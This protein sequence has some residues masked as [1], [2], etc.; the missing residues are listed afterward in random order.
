MS[1]A[2]AVFCVVPSGRLYCVASNLL[3]EATVRDAVRH[4]LSALGENPDRP[5][6]LRTPERV[7]ESLLDLTRGYREPL[8]SIL[9]G[10]V[11]EDPSQ[12]MVLVRDIPFY[13]LCEHHLLPFFGRAHV[14]YIPDGRLMGL[15]KIPRVIEHF[16][17][18]LQVQERLTE[19]VAEALAG[20]LRPR[21]LGV[22]L[23]A[24]HLCMVMRGV[25]KEGSV[26]ATSALRGNFLSDPRARAE[27]LA[28]AG[29][30]NPTK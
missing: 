3:V 17:R 30:P 18:R 21:G 7:E 29:V 2:P 4:I 25:Q 28:L 13:S 14:A 1:K 24:T 20:A 8:D 22:V 9:N 19:Q 26:A 12:A 6:L 10:A 27:F 5:E 23:E 15:S 16:A 11:F